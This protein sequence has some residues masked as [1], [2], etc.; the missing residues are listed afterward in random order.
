[1]ETKKCTI[2]KNDLPAT[3][4]YFAGRVDK[5]KPTFQSSCRECHKQYRKD[6]YEAN[7]Q[8]YI[9]KAS[10]YNQ[11]IVDW[12]IEIKKTLSCLKCGESRWW[13]LDFHHRDPSEKEGDVSLLVRRGSKEK[14]LNELDKCDVLCSNC[15]RDLHY[16]ERQAGDA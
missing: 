12:F 6:H 10:V 13:V 4:E 15:H 5:K 3:S 9:D 1:M 11:S 8:K 2:C 14:I 16:K 7:K